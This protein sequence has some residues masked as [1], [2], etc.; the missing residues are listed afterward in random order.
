[1]PGFMNTTCLN[2]YMYIINYEKSHSC[3]ILTNF[4]QISIICITCM[5]YVLFFLVFF[6]NHYAPVSQAS[7]CNMTFTALIHALVW[8]NSCPRQDLNTGLQHERQT[9]CQLSYPPPIMLM[10]KAN[11]YLTVNCINLTKTTFV[12]F[13]LL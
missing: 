11:Y 7:W 5:H 12:L 4:T 9:T 2:Q 8:P 1:M 3:H 13:T 6:K 10:I